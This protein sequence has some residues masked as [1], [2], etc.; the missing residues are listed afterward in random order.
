MQDPNDTP[1]DQG[2]IWREEDIDNPNATTIWGLTL[3]DF[4]GPPSDEEPQK[5]LGKAIRAARER[6]YWTLKELSRE[7]GLSFGHINAM[8]NGRVYGSIPAYVALAK[9]LDL[10]VWRLF[11]QAGF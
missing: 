3:S 8:E 10:E 2:R 6:K 11:R 9:A 5:L 4:D 7:C 1:N